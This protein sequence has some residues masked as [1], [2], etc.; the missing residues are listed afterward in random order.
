MVFLSLCDFDY[1]GASLEI[2]EALIQAQKTSRHLKRAISDKDLVSSLSREFWFHCFSRP[3]VDEEQDKNK[4]ESQT[5]P[6]P[7]FI[8]HPTMFCWYLKHERK[9]LLSSLYYRPLPIFSLCSFLV[10]HD[11]LDLLKLLNQKAPE[12]YKT[13][14][15]MVFLSLRLNRFECF[16]YLVSHTT[17]NVGLHAMNAA[18][19]QGLIKIVKYLHTRIPMRSCTTEAMDL[20]AGNG[21]LEIVKFL[22]LNRRDEG[23]TTRA[24]D[25]ASKRGHAKV[26]QYL[27]DNRNEGFTERA[28]RLAASKEIVNL[29][30]KKASS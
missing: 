18:C 30:Q 23:C 12:F 29:L 27:L 21:H 10:I 20:A 25:R 16:W 2:L 11:R 24:I 13:R 3:L 17:A 14:N 19:A 15:S 9:L 8:M 28:I 1:R 26:V 5:W 6:K 22:H 7:W 4:L